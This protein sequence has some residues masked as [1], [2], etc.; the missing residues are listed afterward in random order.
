MERKTGWFQPKLS[1]L[2]MVHIHWWL[3]LDIYCPAAISDLIILT[4]IIVPH[5]G[6]ITSL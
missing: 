4:Q 2:A 6:Q 5:P 3:D 1:N